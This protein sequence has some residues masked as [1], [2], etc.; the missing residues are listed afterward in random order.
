MH[1]EAE[2]VGA[3]MNGLRAKKIASEALQKK[4]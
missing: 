4:R 3:A 2:E 1:V